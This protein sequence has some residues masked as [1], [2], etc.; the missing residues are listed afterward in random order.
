[1]HYSL[2]WEIERERERECVCMKDRDDVVERH[3]THILA[4]YIY[5]FQ[6][7]VFDSM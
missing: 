1:M 3:T 2:K 6:V 4:R 5:I 7:Y